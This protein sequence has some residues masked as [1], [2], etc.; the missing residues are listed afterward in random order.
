MPYALVIGK[1]NG[2]ATYT[3]VGEIVY[4]LGI[5]TYF[6]L[7]EYLQDESFKKFFGLILLFILG[8]VVIRNFFYYRQI[9]AQ[10]L[11]PWQAESARVAANEIIVVIGCSLSLA[12]ASVTKKDCYKSFLQ[13]FFSFS[14]SL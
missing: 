1:L 10:A 9:I 13:D 3:A 12:V 5:F 6:P 4:L 8:F 11:L 7:R 2:A 14:W